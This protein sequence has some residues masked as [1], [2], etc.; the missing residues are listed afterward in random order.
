MC[1]QVIT[2]GFRI[3]FE[4]AGESYQVHTDQAGD[5]I[6][7]ASDLVTPPEEDD[8]VA[9]EVPQAALRFEIPA[10]WAQLEGEWAWV[11]EPEDDHKVGLN[12]AELQPPEELEA[13]LLPQP[14]QTLESEELETPLGPGREYLVE[15]YGPA[16]EG[17]QA[18]VVAFERH[19][20]VLVSQN[21]TRWGY[22]FYASAPTQ[23]ALAILE[24][25]LTHM[26]ITASLEPI[27]APPAP[28]PEA[29]LRAGVAQ[30]LGVVP[31][32]VELT[33]LEPVQWPDA[34]LGLAEEDELCAQVITPGYRATAV[35]NDRRYEVRSDEA[36]NRVE[37]VPAAV[38]RA[39]AV[40]ARSLGVAEDEIELV[41]VEAVEWPDAC[42]GVQ[43]EGRMCLQVITPGYRIVF[44]VAGQQH[45]VHTDRTGDAVAIA[46]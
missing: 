38:A 15:V 14:S 29:A 9:V 21:G 16:V 36:V 24:P 23:D 17:E 33:A 4:V 28:E 1:A 45:R 5:A 40:L 27:P 41:R 7:I 12:W 43:E 22:G 30:R 39:R 37:L 32:A 26:V 35:V 44:E 13:V 46:P 18:P 34:C 20:L 31:E 6:A 25:T 19:V 11:R 2:P 10:T 42:L 3:V 8:Y